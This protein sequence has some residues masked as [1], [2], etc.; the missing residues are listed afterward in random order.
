MSTVTEAVPVVAPGN[1]LGRSVRDL[2]IVARRNLIRMSRIP[3]PAGAYP[4]RFIS[5]RTRDLHVS[6][7]K[8]Q[9]K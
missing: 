8:E 5:P 7:G 6:A 3:N 1:P 4:S 2:L 9:A